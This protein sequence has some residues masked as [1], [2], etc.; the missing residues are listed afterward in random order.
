M[1][2]ATE[3]LAEREVLWQPRLRAVSLVCE[4]DIPEN[5]VRTTLWHLGELYAKVYERER[6]LRLLNRLS[7]C[8]V[9][10]LAGIGAVEYQQGAF[11]PAVSD[12]MDMQLNNDDKKLLGEAFRHGLDRFGLARFTNFSRI[13]VDEILMHSGIPLFCLGDFLNALLRQQAL[14]PDVLTPEEFMEWATGPGRESRLHALDK[15]VQRLLWHGGVYVE[16]L[17]DRC[18]ELVDRLREPAFVNDGLQLPD[19]LVAKALD[20]AKSGLLNLSSARET[21]AGL[22]T[23]PRLL[24]EPYGRGLM[25]WLPPIPDAPLGQVE[26]DLVIGGQPQT[27]RSRSVLPAARDTAPAVSVPLPRPVREVEVDLR[28]FDLSLAL[29][30]VDAEDPL[31]VFTD[32]GRRIPASASLPPTSVWLMHPRGEDSDGPDP[33]EFSGSPVH[34]DEP[35]APYGWAGWRLRRVN[36][37]D[38]ARI[39]L[40]DKPWRNVEGGRRPQLDLTSPVRHVR[41]RLDSPV[42][43]EAPNLILPA[44]PGTTTGWTIRIRRPGS[45]QALSVQDIEVS[46]DTRIDPWQG[47]KRPLVG[48][49]EIAVRGPLGRGIS[50][51]FEFAEGFAASWTPEWRELGYGGLQACSVGATAADPELHLNPAVV[52]LAPE[53]ASADF[54][55][56]AHGEE[57]ALRVTPPH[58]A[59]QHGGTGARAEWALRPL[60]LDTEAVG[61]GHL[62]VLLPGNVRAD[63]VVFNGAEQAQRI[64]ASGASRPGTARFELAR[65]AETVQALGTA[66]LKV[67]LH[68]LL[69]PVAK[70][71]P[72]SLAKGVRI[73]DSGCLVVAGATAA[74]GLTAGI[75]RGL[76]PWQEPYVTAVHG[77][78]R[79]SP[80]PDSVTAA[81]DLVVHL[82]I[83][84]P[85]VPQDWPRWPEPTNTFLIRDRPWRA[86]D[87]GDS[88]EVALSRYLAGAGPLPM[89]SGATR[90]AFNLYDRAD[91][92]KALGA[93]GD[94]RAVAAKL[95][96]AEP[97]TALQ[98]ILEGRPAPATTVAPLIH[99]GFAALPPRRY[100]TDDDEVSLWVINPLAAVL[101]SAHQLDDIIVRSPLHERLLTVCGAELF[102]LLLI[103]DPDPHARIG[104]FDASA[105]LLA[106]MDS[107]SLDALWAATPVVPGA[108]LDCDERISA[109]RELFDARLRPGIVSLAAATE[110]H[111]RL[112]VPV[113]ENAGGAELAQAVRARDQGPGWRSLPALSIA[114]CLASR[115]AARG[116]EHL[117]TLMPQLTEAHARLA[118]HSPQLT[119]IDVVLAEL[120]VTGSQ[121]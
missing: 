45:P 86:T 50:Q 83:D 101:A 94:L 10:G 44:D 108:L 119:T 12:Q 114:L 68:G 61:E 58:L 85:W 42:W 77:D 87:G 36:L 53:Q 46:E 5:E 26:W 17:V 102:D 71:V 40:R 100:L 59:V 11:W 8:V 33:V 6:H 104:S 15:P 74:E 60:R 3:T 7:A 89:S 30:V 32:E 21:G 105:E 120:L 109:A 67:D 56:A 4:L 110:R 97:T 22:G 121:L 1:S 113:I 47:V 106:Q 103:G 13:N 57:Y 82:R 14:D 23:R 9:V 24:L 90:L 48:A 16:D 79:S 91:D 39:R 117:A 80:L 35:A 19:S 78:L 29:P 62:M 72:R 107:D 115:L 41:S 76:A 98:S 64:P 49:Y 73:D 52:R 63:L 75:Y 111:L 99:A 92:L 28:E 96:T 95:I 55:V 112:L 27:V 54:I 38:V 20:L 70:C 37:A 84:D 65:V 66:E 69:F 2:R 43:T 88:D 18:L 25:A 93:H 31:M 51:R 118:R 116:Y 34:E 81:G